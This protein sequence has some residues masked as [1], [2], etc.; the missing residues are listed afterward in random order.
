VEIQLGAG[1]VE[2]LFEGAA[3][4]PRRA[5]FFRRHPAVAHFFQHSDRSGP[6]IGDPAARARWGYEK[7]L[8]RLAQPRDPLRRALEVFG[9]MPLRARLS[10]DPFRAQS[11]GWNATEGERKAE[12]R[13]RNLAA[14]DDETM[15]QL[16]VALADN[17]GSD[18][19]LVFPALKGA[20]KNVQ[21]QSSSSHTRL[22]RP[23]N[24]GRVNGA[25]PNA[26]TPRNTTSKAATAR[27]S[28]DAEN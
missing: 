10:L 21:L 14:L 1:D 8:L 25:T 2:W 20:R 11:L 16:A 27:P 3:D 23:A 24:W 17:I 28:A 5:D 12:D 15:L 22:T 18:P 13:R 26:R 6:G 4:D 7:G 9:V 19:R